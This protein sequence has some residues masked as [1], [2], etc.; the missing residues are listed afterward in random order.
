MKRAKHSP[1]WEHYTVKDENA[2]CKYCH[3]VLKYNSSTT[4]MLYHL[5]SQHPT[6]VVQV[7]SGT[8][9]SQPTIMSVLARRGCSDVRAEAITQ[10]LCFM[11][12][13]DMMPIIVVDGYRIPSRG[14]ITSRVEKRYNE[15]KDELK[16]HKVALTTDCW[17]ALTAESYITVTWHNIDAKNIVA[18]NYPTRAN[19]HSVPC[20]AHTFQLAINDG[21]ASYMH[22][23]ITAGKL[24]RNLNHSTVATKALESK[25]QQMKLPAHR[26]I[27]SCKTRWNSARCLEDCWSSAGQ[28]PLDRTPRCQ[29]LEL[30]DEYWQLMEDVAPVLG[31]L[32]CATTIMSAEKEVSISNTYPI[33]F[34]LINS[35]LLRK[36]GDS[37]RL[38]EFKSK[39]RASL[40]ERMK[41]Q[42]PDLVSSPAL[43]ASMLDP[44]Y[45]HLGFLTS[46]KRL[47]ANAKLLELAAAVPFD[48]DG[49]IPTSDE[50]GAETW[51]EDSAATAMVLL[52]GDQYFSNASNSAETEVKNFLGDNPAPL[53]VNHVNWWKANTERFPRVAKLARQY[54]CIPG[55]SVPS[56][57]VF[58]AAGL[59]VN[60]LR[61][62]LTPDHV[63]MLIFLNKTS[64]S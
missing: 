59:R 32:K 34:S 19:W 27:Q 37:S 44:R 3:T 64:R 1:A 49:G 62:Q 60:R 36:E 45:K 41:V 39:V 17:T 38:V 20:F 53:D 22:R 12:E 52:L 29:S 9:S 55:T 8:P 4:S 46:E 33:T 28:L 25:Q 57:R 7:E 21:F 14:T 10:R 63:D 40:D 30:K 51:P 15:K 50:Q 18:A 43:I 5:K 56:E 6:V 48:E 42:S 58:S 2:Q 35:H 31:A 24:V 54:L 23:V 61:T 16:A 26:L 11:V 47:L 13:K